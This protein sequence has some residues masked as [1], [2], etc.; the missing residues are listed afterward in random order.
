M[1]QLYRNHHCF[2]TAFHLALVAEISPPCLSV[3][4][5]TSK[6]LKSNAALF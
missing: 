5:A 4:A 2:A 6:L 3:V 1:T